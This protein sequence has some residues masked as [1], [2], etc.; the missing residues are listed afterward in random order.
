MDSK[1][2]RFVGGSRDHTS[3]RGISIPS[4][5]QGLSNQFRTSSLLDRRKEGIHVDMKDT[6]QYTLSYYS[7][8]LALIVAQSRGDSVKVDYF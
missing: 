5:D 2:S 1:L 7:R 4:Y 3:M 8:L 6:S